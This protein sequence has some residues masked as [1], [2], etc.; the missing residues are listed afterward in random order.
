MKKIIFFIITI[1]IFSCKNKNLNSLNSQEKLDILSKVLLDS[2]DNGINLSKC[3]VDIEYLATPKTLFYPDSIRDSIYVLKDEIDYYKIIL[4][5]DDEIFLK[6]QILDNKNID[7]SNLKRFNFLSEN[8]KGD[9]SICKIILSKPLFNKEEDK[10]Y[11]LLDA[12]EESHEY[13]FSKI[14]NDW[15]LIKEW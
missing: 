5:E 6:K 13:V 3:F 8:Q 15:K 14:N 1:F 10:F 12:N 4:N 9:N 11:L 7:F 2:S